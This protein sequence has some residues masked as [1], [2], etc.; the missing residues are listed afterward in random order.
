MFAAD[1]GPL[2]ASAVFRWKLAL[3]AVGLVHAVVFHLL[4]RRRLAGWADDPPALGRLMAVFSVALWLT[5]GAL[6]RWIAYA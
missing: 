1:A 4:W 6:G 2:V 5:V 3:I